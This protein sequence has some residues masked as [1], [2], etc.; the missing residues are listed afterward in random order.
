MSNLLLI[1]LLNIL[2]NDPQF[3]EETQ[4]ELKALEAEALD[5]NEVQ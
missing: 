2:A 4:H 1:K 3:S 5:E